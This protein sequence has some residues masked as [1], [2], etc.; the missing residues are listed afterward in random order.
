MAD[1]I[2]VI[3]DKNVGGAG[4][5]LSTLLASPPLRQGS[6]AVL[7]R[8]SLLCPLFTEK[9][10]PYKT[11]EM[12]EA[13]FSPGDVRALFSLFRREGARLIVS[14]ASLS[15]RIAA[16]LLSIPAV[17]IRH[18]DTPFPAHGLWLY[19]AV[20]SLTV[21]TSKPLEARLRAAG[22]KRL[23]T[24][25][26]GYT[27][28]GIPS[29]TQRERARAQFS[30]TD[31][32]LAIGLA[33][34]LS[35]IKGQ[36]VALRALAATG[37]AQGR[38]TLCFLGA[39]EEEDRLRTLASSLG[40]ADRVRFLG[41]LPDVR[42]FYHAIDAHISCSLGSETSSLSLAEGM[43]AGCPTF[44]SDT[45]GNRARLAG[46]GRLFPVK[47]EGAL[48]R[49]FLSL[50]HEGERKKLSQMARERANALPTL[51]EMREKYK[52]IFD[53]F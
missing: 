3:T 36:D 13:S 44:A 14:H 43:S 51:E 24:V 20:T 34:R 1:V 52:H 23:L 30:L 40:V 29:K 21:A 2:H 27:D 39:G 42:L 28:M 53:A 38:I 8:E 25:E 10:I 35:P 18:C 46:G 50:L 22:V 5:L 47:D 32:T 12:N 19:N 48:S 33:G 17:S 7:P 11:L 49:L 31:D 4:V 45:S 15:S 37:K 26:N 6:L 9:E 41:Y 16:K